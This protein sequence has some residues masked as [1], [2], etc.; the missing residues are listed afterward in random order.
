MRGGLDI[1]TDHHSEQRASCLGLTVSS[2]PCGYLPLLLSKAAGAYA[3]D[4]HLHSSSR[5]AP[6]LRIPLTGSIVCN[7]LRGLA[8]TRGGRGFPVRPVKRKAKYMV[9]CSGRSHARLT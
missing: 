3:E 8:Q 4:A 7:Y 6:L 1:I 5:A 2:S 9:V